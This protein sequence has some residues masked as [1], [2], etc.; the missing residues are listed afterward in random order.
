MPFQLFNSLFVFCL[1]L[2]LSSTTAMTKKRRKVCL[3]RA[4]TNETQ[5]VFHFINMF[6]SIL[7]IFPFFLCAGIIK[8]KK[9]LNDLRIYFRIRFYLVRAKAECPF[10]RRVS[11][12]DFRWKFV[13]IF[14]ICV[15]HSA[16]E[17]AIS[18]VDICISHRFEWWFRRFYLCLILVHLFIVIYLPFKLAN[19]RI[20]ILACICFVL[21]SREN[22]N[23]E[24]RTFP[25]GWL[26]WP[27]ANIDSSIGGSDSGQRGS[28][29]VNYANNEMVSSSC[30]TLFVVLLFCIRLRCVYAYL[31]PLGI[32]WSVWVMHARAH[33]LITFK[34][35]LL[36]C[37]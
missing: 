35:C 7:S 10:C 28:Y 1:L 20:F 13:Y 22:R 9:H 21:F 33:D 11:G 37:K 30:F 16:L 23:D 12:P 14:R 25:H 29:K 3:K 2:S 6:R 26:K 19:G 4:Q 8:E 34:F 18:D 36:F 24:K 27:F 17:S 15:E 31:L 32:H 5:K